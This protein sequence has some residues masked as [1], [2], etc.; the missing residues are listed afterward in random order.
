MIE[1]FQNIEEIENNVEQAI[2]QATKV[3]EEYNSTT[4]KTLNLLEEFS[5]RI[6]T[7]HKTL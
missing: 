4:E 6:K 3:F 5:A 7:T 1:H 2:K